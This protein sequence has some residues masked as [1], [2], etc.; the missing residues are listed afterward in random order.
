[1][2][3]RGYEGEGLTT[4]MP[5]AVE[6][7]QLVATGFEGT[8]KYA[9]AVLKKVRANAPGNRL[10]E[11]GSS[12]GYFLYQ[13]RT[14]GFEVTGVEPSGPRR[15]YGADRLGLTIVPSCEAVPPGSVDVVYTAHSLEH[16]TDLSQIFPEISRTLTRG[17]LVLIEVP[18][19]DYPSGF[20]RRLSMMGAVHPLGFSAGFFRHA[21]SANGFDILGMYDSWGD[22]PEKPTSTCSAGQLLIAATKR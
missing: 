19:F 15:T 2:Y 13:A 1:M 6:L 8:D 7:Q 22:Y 11:V 17:G 14:A 4:R 5:N 16:F 3:D 12:W 20:A 18:N 9:A 10:L 21:L